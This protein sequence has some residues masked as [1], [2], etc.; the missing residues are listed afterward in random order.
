MVRYKDVAYDFNEEKDVIDDILF[1]IFSTLDNTK[2]RVYE[3]SIGHYA[4]LIDL[5]QQYLAITTDGVGTKIVVA[6]LVG[7]YEGLGIDL[8]AMNVNDVI[9]VGARPSIFVDYIA[10]PKLDKKMITEILYGIKKAADESG[11]AVVGG[12]TAI[13]NILEHIELSGTVVGFV[14]KGKEVLGEKI[15]PGDYVVGIESSGIH[16]NGLSLAR[17]VLL[18]KYGADYEISGKEIWK[19]LLEPTRIYVKPILELLKNVEVHGLA[20]I[21]GGAFRKLLRITRYGYSLTP[22]DP[23]EIFTAIMNEGV[24]IDEMYSTFN[25]GIGFVA[26]VPKDS[27]DDAVELLNKYYP[28]HVIGH[29]IEDHIVRIKAMGEEI[30]LSH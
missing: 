3:K 12:E 26:I 9:C 21:T 5:G 24:P 27:L 19:H 14:K 22:P 16:S 4:S 30:V 11:V 23:P 17:K 25:M 29:I 7:K 6:E 20:H 28:T 15:V 1:S 8:V 10:L 18:E 2:E 13:M